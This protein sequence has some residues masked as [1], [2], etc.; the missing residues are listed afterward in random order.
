VVQFSLTFCYLHRQSVGH[1][2]HRNLLRMSCF[3]PFNFEQSRISVPPIASDRLFLQACPF[4]LRRIFPLKLVMSYD[5][6][7]HSN[8]CY[9]YE[10]VPCVCFPHLFPV[11][12][13]IS[14]HQ[15]AHQVYLLL[16]VEII[17]EECEIY[18]APNPSLLSRILAG[19]YFLFHI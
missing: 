4:L 11:E 13:W 12:Y 9:C 8:I 1:P 5:W 2:P 15:F 3:R 7:Q 14:L 17:R 16:L 19:L 10:L 18:R 6:P